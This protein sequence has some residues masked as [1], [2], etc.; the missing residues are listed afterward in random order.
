MR[1]ISRSHS[2][3]TLT[4]SRHGGAAGQATQVVH[5]GRHALGFRRLGT[6]GHACRARGSQLGVHACV[7]ADAHACVRA[8]SSWVL[9][10]QRLASNWSCANAA[11][12]KPL[13]FW[14]AIHSRIC[15]RL[16]GHRAHAHVSLEPQHS[17]SVAAPHGTGA[18]QGCQAHAAPCQPPALHPPAYQRASLTA[19]RAAWRASALAFFSAASPPPAWTGTAKP[20]IS[21]CSSAQAASEPSAACAAGSCCLHRAR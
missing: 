12:A 19:R 17:H 21:C 4:C 18:A 10:A 7:C 11:G 8:A 16:G 2:C 6:K 3:H 14:L 15:R 5:S 9:Q 20:S 13:R 1:F